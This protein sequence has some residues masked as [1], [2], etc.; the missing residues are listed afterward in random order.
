MVDIDPAE[1]KKPTLHPDLAVCGNLK[2][3]LPKFIRLLSKPLGTKGWL[4]HCQQ[5]REQFSPLR[6]FNIK[7]TDR[8]HPYLFMQKLGKILP[9][10]STMVTSNGT[11]CVA[12]LQAFPHKKGQRTFSNSGSASMGYGLPAAI[13]ACLANNKKETVCLEGD[14]SIM[15]NIQ[16]L[17]TLKTL[18]LPVKIFIIKNGEYISI[19]QTQRNFFN[20]RLTGCNAR[21]GV[22]VPDFVKVAKA[23][24]LPAIRID[25][26]KDIE[27]GIKKV[28][29]MKG[30]VVCEFDCISNYIFSPKLSSRKLPDGTMLSPSL[31]DMFP[32]LD[33]K[34]IE[35][36]QFK[37][38]PNNK[39]PK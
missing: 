17:Q 30:P 11:S 4:Q 26:N 1:L 28:L 18:Q 10:Y 29:A 23:F 12:F 39:E 15:M 7:E 24:G 33:R 34:E 6:E 19:I 38:S 32:F 20:G 31:E 9:N 5:L 14:G 8:V 36:A 22:E 35:Q 2:E 21:S 16:E 13:G 3:I 27:T 25:K 37:P